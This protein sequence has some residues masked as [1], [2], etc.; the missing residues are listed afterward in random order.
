MTAPTDWTTVGRQVAARANR[1]PFWVWY[2]VFFGGL[3]AAHDLGW[4]ALSTA[5]WFGALIPSAIA[6][7]VSHGVVALAYGDT[8][9]ERAGRLT[10]NP[11]PH[12]SLGATVLLPIVCALTFGVPFG[13]AKP[14]PVNVSNL[15][16]S[17]NASVYVALA[18]PATNLAILCLLYGASIVAGVHGLV[19]QI[20]SFDAQ[21]TWMLVLFEAGFLNLLLAL[22]NLLPIP[23]LDGSAVIERILPDRAMPRYFQFRQIAFPLVLV[24]VLLGHNILAWPELRLFRWW[25]SVFYGAGA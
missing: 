3:T 4:M 7:E 5:I 6:H 22:F 21:P 2:V 1:A 16:N 25:F 11:L 12:I 17:R 13:A 20:P 19:P 8:T 10:A 14:V 24:V 9:A 15:R 23:P 18:G